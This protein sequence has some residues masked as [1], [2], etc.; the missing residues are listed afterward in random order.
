MSAPAS[1]PLKA[2]IVALPE[3]AGSALYGM[4]D[5]LAAAGSLWQELSGHEP[6]GPLIEPK[7]VGLSRQAFDCGN[8]IPV[9][10]VLAL[11]EEPTG[12]LLIV[13]ELW[14]SPHDDLSDRYG[15]LLEWI[16]RRHR[17]GTPIYSACSGAVLLAASGILDGCEATSHWG[18]QDL[19]RKRFPKV[20]FKPEP[21][22]VFADPAGRI[23]TAGGA[24]SWHD[25]AIHIISRHCGPGEATRIAKA[26]LL[27]WHAEGQSPFSNLVR[28]QPHADA[29]ARRAE[30][31]LQQNFRQARAVSGV[32]AAT[33]ASERT[34]NRRFKAAMGA[35]LMAY[36]QNLRIEETK[37]RLETSAASF[38]DIATETGYENPAFARRVFKRMT[39]LLPREYR[40]MFQPIA[41]GRFAIVD[42]A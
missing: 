39:G 42:A 5:V 4:V 33:G 17:A 26:Y 10:P 15:S 38:E 22:L 13:P 7:I 23:V 12:D 14:L 35:T 11:E 21:N 1:K 37:R 8:K 29:L 27:K 24:T 18:Y 31:W 32:V 36:T 19:F 2:L 6:V 9:R 28:R 41:Q 20:R 3:T 25:L 34:L 30:E 16:R 40:R